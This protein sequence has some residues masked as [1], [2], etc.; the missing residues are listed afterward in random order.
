[1]KSPRSI[2]FIQRQNGLNY[3]FDPTE[4][5]EGSLTIAENALCQREGTVEPRRGL[6]RYGSAATAQINA[7]LEYKGSLL[8]QVGVSTLQYD[9]GA[10]S[11]ATYAAAVSP[12]VSGHKVR[13][14]EAQRVHFMTSLAGVLSQEYLSAEPRRSGIEPALELT[15]STSGT[16][17]G[18]A[19]P[20]NIIG[21]RL[22]WG[23]LDEYETLL[24]GRPSFPE[25]I[26]SAWISATYTSS[27]STITVTTPSAHGYTTGDSVQI[28]N[29][30]DDT[31]L[32]G[33]FVITVTDT[34]EF[35]YTGNGTPTP[36][37]GDL[38]CGKAY[39]VAIESPIPDDVVAGDFYEVY[40]TDLSGD[41]STYPVE[42]YYRVEQVEVTSTDITAGYVSFTDDIAAG[43]MGDE[44]YTN[45]TAGANPRPN[46]RPPFARD[47]AL[48]EGHLLLVGATWEQEVVFEM[49]SMDSLVDDTS[50]I[51]IGSETYTFSSAENVSLKKF[52]RWTTYST[53]A[54]N[55]A[56]TM[57][58]LV[59]VMNRG[60][61][62]YYGYYT[63]YPTDPPGRVTI[64][65]RALGGSYFALTA[66]AT[67]TGANFTPNFPTGGTAV[68]STAPGGQN[69][70]ALS[71]FEQP[72][73]VPRTSVEPLGA[74][75]R[76]L[77]RVLALRESAIIVGEI[78]VWVL[79]GESD[80][81]VGGSFKLKQ[82]DQT[83]RIRGPDTAAV[84]HN[85]AY[86]FSDQGFV[87]IDENGV[88]IVGRQ[89]EEEVEKRYYQTSWD[90]LAFA[91]AYPS[92]NL[93]I[94]FAPHESSDSV[95]TRAWC[96]NVLTEKFTHGWVKH[97]SAAIVLSSD[98]KLYLAHGDDYYTLQERKTYLD[99][100]ADY[101]DEE[102]SATATAVSTTENDAGD[103]V[104]LVTVTYS[105]SGASL[106]SGWRVTQG[107]YS[108]EVDVVT[109][110]GSSSYSLR[111]T[112]LVSG[113]TTGAVTLTMPIEL[114]L[115][116]APVVGRN[117]ALLKHFS[118]VHF[119]FESNHAHRH[120]VGFSSDMLSGESFNT[121]AHQTSASASGWGE[122]GWGVTAWGD[123]IGGVSPLIVSLPKDYARARRL[124]VSYLHRV[125]AERAVLCQVSLPVR[126]IGLRSAY[127]EP[128]V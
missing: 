21:Y 58:S 54:E 60:S 8:R 82:R 118:E 49:R 68:A 7:H 117:A 15:L 38:D 120:F 103:T 14:V 65:H 48:F 121:I 28:A 44:L 47:I 31:N 105:Y 4:R 19:Q 127:K 16:G 20:G 71:K 124:Q 33:T 36:A 30:D 24:L 41:D 94:C 3:Q 99:T 119:E 11:W 26:T 98:D 112:D 113:I 90:T 107:N 32:A 5:P 69:Y 59:R 111:L 52:K 13:G 9:S 86:C 45:A 97:V 18:P 80:G 10:G 23:R 37:S 64:R 25:Y 79:S 56:A 67:A 88:F 125:V 77:E 85:K 93:Y 84:L 96:Y 62:V 102:L 43:F 109:D 126:E 2:E 46:D 66:N 51:T 110:L 114:H 116:W 92:E 95:A 29:T 35:T 70:L 106:A 108:G 87:A 100:L 76:A 72:H 104:S 73:A 34:D 1:M 27:G 61:S 122:L 22:L 39:N 50:T 123:D 6:A 55:V 63:S 81:S 40:R 101:A 78:G 42:T 115:Q 74:A 91:V 12:P 128:S 75:D 17:L 83:L 57:K 89:I 53:L